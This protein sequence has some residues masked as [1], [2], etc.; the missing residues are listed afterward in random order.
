MHKELDY[1]DDSN[2]DFILIND[3][4]VKSVT[5]YFTKLGL[6]LAITTTRSTIPQNGALFRKNTNIIAGYIRKNS[7]K[8]VS[9]SVR[10]DCTTRLY[11]IYSGNNIGSEIIITLG[12]TSNQFNKFTWKIKK[13]TTAP[14]VPVNNVCGCFL[15]Q[16]KHFMFLV[17]VDPDRKY[18]CESSLLFNSESLNNY[19]TMFF[20]RA[21]SK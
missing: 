7:R 17:L 12:Q 1:N 15:K 18:Q 4:I 6:K 8:Y 9:Y 21:A 14:I 19:V 5:E 13:D 11:S 3:S 10:I 2:A 16:L 20:P